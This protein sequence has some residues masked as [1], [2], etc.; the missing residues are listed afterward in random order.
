MAKQTT[1]YIFLLEVHNFLVVKVK[2]LDRF[3]D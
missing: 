1:K 2:H 3:T